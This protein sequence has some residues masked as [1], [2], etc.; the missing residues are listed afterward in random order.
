MVNGLA[1]RFLVSV[2]IFLLPS[3]SALAHNSGL[4]LSQNS[5]NA[6]QG[7]VKSLGFSHHWS[8]GGVSGASAADLIGS[9][10]GTLENSP[11]KSITGPLY[12]S[13]PSLSLNGSTQHVSTATSMTSPDTFTANI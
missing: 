9:N 1:V 8:V 5:C 12:G 2:F 7:L 4:M 6:Y 11:T 10:T 3:L 13:S